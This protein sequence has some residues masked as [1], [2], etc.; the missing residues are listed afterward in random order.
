MLQASVTVRDAV[1]G[2]SLTATI[3]VGE[4]RRKESSKYA[5]KTRWRLLCRKLKKKKISTQ[6]PWLLLDLD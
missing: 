2:V 5:Y 4:Q 6:P 3:N 1:S